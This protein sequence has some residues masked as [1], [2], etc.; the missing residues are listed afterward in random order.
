MKMTIAAL[1]A[2]EREV[3]RRTMSATFEFFD[4]DYE[5]R[6][7][8]APE[9]MRAL[10]EGW[11]RVDDSL[12][13]SDACLA[14]NNALNDLLHGVGISDAD[15]QR[16]TGVNREEMYRIYRKWAEHRGWSSTGVR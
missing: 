12:D 11:S 5:T 1:T 4:F 13:D 10:L 15:A 14:I 6:L 2:E 16:L 7:G 8:V 9:T 3:V